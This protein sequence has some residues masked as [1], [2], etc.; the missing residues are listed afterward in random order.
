MPPPETY[1]YGHSLSPP[2]ALPIFPAHEH[3]DASFRGHAAFGVPARPAAVAAQDAA[4]GKGAGGMI[5]RRD[6]IVGGLCAG[7]MGAASALVPRTVMASHRDVTLDKAIPKTIGPWQ[8][9][10]AV[11]N[12]LPQDEGSLSAQAY[13]QLVSRV[14]AGS[15]RDVVMMVTAYGD[16]QSDTLQLHRHTAERRGGTRD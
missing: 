12:V 7:G 3:R 16:S 15:G 14:Y 8:Q 11:G 10:E 6:L 13:S 4:V 5:S 1:T 9:I 2:D